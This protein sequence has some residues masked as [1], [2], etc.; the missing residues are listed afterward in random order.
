MC[1]P[2]A[3]HVFKVEREWESSGL[4]CAVVQGREGG[5]R[6][7][8]VRVSPSHPDHGKEYDDVDVDVHGGLTYA[9]LE[10]CTDHADGQGYW[11]G[12]DCA[13]LGDASYDPNNLPG[14]EI[15]FRAKYPEFTEHNRSEHFWS[16][17]EVIAETERLARQ[18]AER[19]C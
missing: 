19:S 7:G 3:E 10:P 8:Y 4:L 9:A 5:N 14:H 6:C 17:Q 1:L 2:N 16:E 12:F 15:A 11:F 13:H 18:L